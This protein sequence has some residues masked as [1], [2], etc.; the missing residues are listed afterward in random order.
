MKE[1]IHLSVLFQTLTIQSLLIC[2]VLCHHIFYICSTCTYWK[3]LGCKVCGSHDIYSVISC[4]SSGVDR[5]QHLWKWILKACDW[6]P[7]SADTVQLRLPWVSA[8]WC[9]FAA[10]HVLFLSL[11]LRCASCHKRPEFFTVSW[12]NKKSLV[13]SRWSS[14][15][16][17][18]PEA[19]RTAFGF[20]VDRF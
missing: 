14:W 13:C 20:S 11:S 19:E 16:F 15:L 3:I 7:S 4:S 9:A 5:E 18:H 2:D 8:N 1:K 10:S 12:D 6:I 17:S